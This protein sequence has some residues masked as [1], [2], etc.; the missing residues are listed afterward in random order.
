MKKKKTY[1]LVDYENVHEK[2]LEGADKLGRNDHVHL[3]FTEQSHNI[4]LESVA[5]MNM[6]NMIAHKT[7]VGE[8]SLDKHLLSYLG[9]LIGK[10]GSKTA[11]YIIVSSD[12]GYDRINE[13]WNTYF[14]VKVTRQSQIVI[15]E[16]SPEALSLK[17][18]QQLEADLR[19]LLEQNGFSGSKASEISKEI[20][21]NYEKRNFRALAKKYINKRFAD[22]QALA[23]GLSELVDSSKKKPQ[24]RKPVKRKQE[25]PVK[26]TETP[27][28]DEKK[29]VRK[30]TGVRKKTQNSEKT[31]AKQTP[32]VKEQTVK[33][34]P[35]PKKI[36]IRKFTSKKKEGTEAA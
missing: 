12:K 22:Q 34:K 25:A 3:F 5:F 1:Y 20:L 17:Q 4:K 10:N 23:K 32:A 6:V 14:D 7:T 21:E 24:V 16:N 27:K 9:Y 30:K 33:Q 11:D 36:T 26:K 31:A 15:D 18:K 2:G 8:E 28:P 13:F 19:T 35:V 29:T